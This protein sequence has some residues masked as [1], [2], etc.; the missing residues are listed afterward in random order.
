MDL[1]EKINKKGTENANSELKKLMQERA[2]V[3]ANIERVK[4]LAPR[5]QRLWDICQAMLDNGFPLG[6]IEYYVGFPHFEFET[7][8]TFHRLGFKVNRHW[9]SLRGE[10]IGR[11]EIIGFGIEYDNDSFIVNRDGVWGYYINGNFVAGDIDKIHSYYCGHRNVPQYKIW[12]FTNH[13]NKTLNGFDEFERNVLEYAES[14][15]K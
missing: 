6:K 10:V 5:I 7:E 8:D 11:G 2:T 12:L 15:T 13:I 3:V 1:I 14:I 4:S 9:C